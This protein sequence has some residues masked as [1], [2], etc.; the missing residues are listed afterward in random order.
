MKRNYV[1][2]IIVA[3]N[4]ITQQWA[5]RVID[6]SMDCDR[7]NAALGIVNMITITK[8]RLAG[9]ICFDTFLNVEKSGKFL[10]NT[11]GIYLN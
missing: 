10:K 1:T 3:I 11:P 6:M 5:S 9:F 2:A 8:L 4:L 7:I